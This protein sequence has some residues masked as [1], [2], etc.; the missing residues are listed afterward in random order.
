M[1]AE[2][3]VPDDVLCTECLCQFQAAS[4][5]SSL[6][7]RT[8]MCPACNKKVYYPMRADLHRCFVASAVIG[9]LV[10]VG[11][12]AI[13]GLF[14]FAV[15]GLINN[16]VIKGKIADARSRLEAPEPDPDK[17]ITLTCANCGRT[18]PEDHLYC[19]DCCPERR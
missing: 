8:Y 4:G 12:V 2:S 6:G 3:G 9:A 10:L 16:A 1:S 7:F 19:P 13:G 15:P 18:L 14:V 17:P 11:G 5:I